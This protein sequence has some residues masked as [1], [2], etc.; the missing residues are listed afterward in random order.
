MF[1]LDIQYIIT[2]TECIRDI[3]RKAGSAYQFLR[4][5][6]AVHLDRSKGSH[7]FQLQEVAFSGLFMN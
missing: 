7:T 6:L 5:A 3:E 1:N 2:I 4:I